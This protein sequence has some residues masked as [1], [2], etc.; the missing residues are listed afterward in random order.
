MSLSGGGLSG[1]GAVSTGKVICW[2]NNLGG[3]LGNGGEGTQST[4]PV[5]VDGITNATAVG[6]GEY[7]SCALLASGR[8]DCWGG[9]TW[10]QLGDGS[11]ESSSTPV[12]VSGIASAVALGVGDYSACAVLADGHVECWETAKRTSSVTV[13]KKA[14]PP[15]SKLAASQTPGPWPSARGPPAPCSKTVA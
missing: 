3:E 1:C 15:P 10:G 14:A 2:G 6:T 5:L 13:A 9:S 11:E 4:T 12:E 7:T 8:I